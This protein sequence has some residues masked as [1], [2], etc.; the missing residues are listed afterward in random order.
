M[1]KINFYLLEYAYAYI[2]RN[3]NKNIFIVVVFTL[4]V[5]LLSSIFFLTTTLQHEMQERIAFQ[6]DIVVEAYQAGVKT[7]VKST[8]LDKL[9]EINGISSGHLRVEGDYTFSAQNVKFHLYGVA[10]FEDQSDPLI[11]E[12]LQTQEL[13][14]TQMLVSTYVKDI[15]KKAYYTEY[16]NFIKPDGSL[17]KIY[18][19]DSFETKKR[20]DLDN[21]ILLDQESLRE[22]F[23]F[24]ADEGSDIAL[25]VANKNELDFITSKLRLMLPNAKVTSKNDLKL[26]YEKL[27]DYDSGIFL[28]LFVISIFTFFIIIY[29]KANGLSSEEKREIG[30]L[31]AIGWRVEDVLHAKFYEAA[32]ISFFS[33]FVGLTFAFLYVFVLKAP[34]LGEIFMHN[35]ILDIHTFRLDV[36]L[37]LSYI[38][39]IF[40]LSVPVYIAATLIPSWRVATIDADEVM[41]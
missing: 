37:E 34:L 21:L 7:T 4:L 38:L 13:N 29:D 2:K 28:S 17:K 8:L 6:P 35:T 40:L 18:I 16:F 39:L 30:I 20:K 31:K 19:K 1:S 25:S 10:P 36:Y 15:M 22:I 23:G 32:I 26:Q 5:T 41:R 3:K 33:F 9:L 11:N 24:S 27:F 12:V 14:A